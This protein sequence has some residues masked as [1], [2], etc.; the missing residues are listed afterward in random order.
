MARAPKY[1]PN[2]DD[3]ETKLLA[4]ILQ[5]RGR[6]LI[7][8]DHFRF[9]LSVMR[10]D[11]PSWTWRGLRRFAAAMRARTTLSTL[12]EEPSDKVL[13]L[14]KMPR[15]WKA[16]KATR[17]EVQA[18]PRGLL[19]PWPLINKLKKKFADGDYGLGYKS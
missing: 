15:T 12:V 7:R 6:G 9:V 3:V 8:D 1:P 14:D 16:S 11:D 5:G 10:K 17:L 4:A 19:I 13:S 18:T 2:P